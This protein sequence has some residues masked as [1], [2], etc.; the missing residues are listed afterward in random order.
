M[1]AVALPLAS[2]ELTTLLQLKTWASTIRR[3]CPTGRPEVGGRFALNPADT[4][5]SYKT[6]GSV[7]SR[8]TYPFSRVLSVKWIRSQLGP[9]TQVIAVATAISVNL[10]ASKV[11]AASGENK[12][13]AIVR[14]LELSAH[15]IR[16]LKGNMVVATAF[17]YSPSGRT[18]T[19]VAT[20]YFDAARPV[21]EDESEPEASASIRF[22]FAPCIIEPEAA[23]GAL[24][25][26][27]SK[28][29]PHS[30][31]IVGRQFDLPAAHK[32]RV[33]FDV[34]QNPWHVVE[35]RSY[36]P[37]D[38][39]ISRTR[40]LDWSEVGPGIILPLSVTSWRRAVY[41]TLEQNIVYSNVVAQGY[42]R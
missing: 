16:A 41:S 36:G 10:M 11:Y 40:F 20:E 34:E 9:W 3:M 21:G 2:T 31:T 23:I 17:T 38:V 5:V 27:A 1:K 39:L 30:V 18:R 15:K 12:A 25:I 13:E 29:G 24:E 14:A 4:S 42:A 19:Q 7:G 35:V 28:Q 8:A 26:S 32:T 37:T 6:G 22:H 33:E